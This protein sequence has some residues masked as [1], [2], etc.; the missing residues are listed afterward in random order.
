MQ[1]RSVDND[2]CSPGRVGNKQST[3]VVFADTLS[4]VLWEERRD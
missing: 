2:R 1:T 4:S 3:A